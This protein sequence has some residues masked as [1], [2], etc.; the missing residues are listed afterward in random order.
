MD[1]EQSRNTRR[2]THEAFKL[3]EDETR[4]RIV[5]MLREDELEVKEIAERLGM[6]PQN[7]YH[8]MN[9][10]EDAGI[11]QMSYERRQGHIIKSYYTTSAENFFYNDDHMPQRPLKDFTDILYGLNETG[12]NVPVRP[13][14]AEK[15]LHAYSGYMEAFPAASMEVCSVCSFSGFFMKL[16]P[17]NPVLLRRVLH[18]ADLL[19]LT[20][21]EFDDHLEKYRQLR[22]CLKE[23]EG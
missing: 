11:V 19:K 18:F 23:L 1:A 13:G 17:Y 12:F 15:L 14:N 9:K 10:L 7:I 16:G 8:H 20:D 3:L 5:F 22:D 2:I 21:K 4:R 6:T